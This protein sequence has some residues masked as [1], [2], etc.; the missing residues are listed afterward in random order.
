MAIC[1]TAA[2]CLH[3]CAHIVWFG[4]M[5]LR[6]GDIYAALEQADLFVSIGTSGVVYPRGFV[7]DAR[8]HRAHPIEI[9]LEPS[10]VESEF[11]EKRYGKPSIELPRLVEEILAAQ[12]RAKRVQKCRWLFM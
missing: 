1:A 10:A 4:E 6:M 7:H 12:A 9:N 3:R 5:P 2:K 11:A 8:M